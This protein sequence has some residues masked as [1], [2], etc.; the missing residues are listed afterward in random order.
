MIFSRFEWDEKKARANI[1]KH[2]LSFAEAIIAFDDDFAIIQSDEDHGEQRF[3]LI[4]E[5]DVGV[6]LV[7]F[8]E[9]EDA[10]RIISA[11]K[12]T[13]KERVTYEQNKAVQV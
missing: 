6:V 4:G 13:R 2:G 3:V 12:G 10:V 8:V 7:A 5:A 1:R 11:R 9:R